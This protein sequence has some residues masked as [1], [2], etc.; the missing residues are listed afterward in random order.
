MSDIPENLPENKEPAEGSRENLNPPP[1][2]SPADAIG[3]GG[4]QTGAP[5]PRPRPNDPP[6]PQRETHTNKKS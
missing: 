2:G 1:E 5:T 4:R 3:G 6:R